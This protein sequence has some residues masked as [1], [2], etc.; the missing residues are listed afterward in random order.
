MPQAVPLRAGVHT[1]PPGSD[2]PLFS[3]DSH[4]I[5]PLSSST[6]VI[7]FLVP[8]RV[9]C[10]FAEYIDSLKGHDFCLDIPQ[11]DNMMVSWQ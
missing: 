6:F 1:H 5:R 10:E 4:L 11:D 8:L 7:Y 3:S 9:I 2:L